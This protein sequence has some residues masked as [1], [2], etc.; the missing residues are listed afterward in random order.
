MVSH[1]LIGESELDEALAECEVHL[2]DPG[3]ITT[4]LP[5]VPGVGPRGGLN[6]GLRRG[7]AGHEHAISEIEKGPGIEITASKR[8]RLAALRRPRR[9]RGDAAGPLPGGADVA[10][11]GAIAV[12]GASH[13]FP[14][15]C[16][17]RSIPVGRAGS[18]DEVARLVG[19]I[20]AEDIPFLTAETIDLNGGQGVAR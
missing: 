7:A 17:A 1:G 13:G 6:G 20:L 18:A 9:A 19:A 4:P 15:A 16:L 10:G 8:R 11:P 14:V 12:T 5:G 3:T 2:G